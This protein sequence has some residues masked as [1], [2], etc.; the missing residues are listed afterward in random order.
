M[1]KYEDDHKPYWPEFEFDGII[2][3]YVEELFPSYKED[4]EKA[5]FLDQEEKDVVMTD[6][7]KEADFFWLR[8]NY[9][10][11]A[12]LANEKNYVKKGLDIWMTEPKKSDVKDWFEKIKGMSP[13]SI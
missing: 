3:G 1:S 2:Q 11:R 6:F 5:H 8:Y 4:L 13:N 12:F 7:E 9:S 10:L